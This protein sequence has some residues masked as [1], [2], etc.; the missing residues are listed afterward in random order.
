MIY[1]ISLDIAQIGLAAFLVN[2]TSNQSPEPE[3]S[4]PPDLKP[5]E[6]TAT[7]AVPDS[8]E[9]SHKTNS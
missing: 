1:I 3:S 7:A 8:H 6:A 2:R 5:T 4:E 9:D